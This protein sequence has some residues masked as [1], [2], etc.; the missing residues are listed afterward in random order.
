MFDWPLKRQFVL[1][2]KVD[3]RNLLPLGRGPL[4][5]LLGRRLP[6]AIFIENKVGLN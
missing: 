1:E 2:G 5:R 3:G 4:G 6:L